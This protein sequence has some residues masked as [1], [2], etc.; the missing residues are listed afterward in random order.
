MSWAAAEEWRGVKDRA[1]GAG[2]WAAAEV[3]DGH[4]HKGVVMCTYLHVKLQEGLEVNA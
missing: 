4:L 3:L 1:E 2:G